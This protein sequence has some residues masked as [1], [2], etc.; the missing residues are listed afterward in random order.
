MR[1]TAKGASSRLRDEAAVRSE[2]QL[3]ALSGHRRYFPGSN[4]VQLLGL[5]ES[6]DRTI[7]DYA[8]ANGFTIVSLDADFAEMAA[9]LLPPPKIIWLRVGNQPRATIATFL[10]QG[11]DLIVT[12]EHDDAVC[13][14]IY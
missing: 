10:R 4:H 8:K 14:E 9:L 5:H 11:A 1:R 2:P 6:D 13:L 12:L 3:Q 7:W